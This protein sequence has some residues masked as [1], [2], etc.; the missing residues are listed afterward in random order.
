MEVFMEAP[1]QF[2]TDCFLTGP[3]ATILV[4]SGKAIHQAELLGSQYFRN[5]LI[6]EIRESIYGELGEKEKVF[7]T[8][9]LM[10]KADLNEI[11]GFLP[12]ERGEEGY[13]GLF[14]DIID[15]IKK[16]QSRHYGAVVN[17]ENRIG[18]TSKKKICIL[19]NMSQT[20]QP[21]PPP[22]LI[23][24]SNFGKV[25]IRSDPPLPVSQ[26]G[27][28]VKKSLKYENEFW[29]TFQKYIEFLIS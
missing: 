25:W 4:K 18:V 2:R 27:H 17:H 19:G 1:G 9:E 20:R 21:P 8:E 11:F 5:E 14:Y 12:I 28:C 16:L 29:F 6:K 13:I 7:L 26:L 23:G 3:R 10:D 15:R 22:H 24:T